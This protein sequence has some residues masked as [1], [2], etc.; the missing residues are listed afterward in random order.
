VG[1]SRV[2]LLAFHSNHGLTPALKGSERPRCSAPRGEPKFRV[3]NYRP[4]VMERFGL[5]FEYL[6]EACPRLVYPSAFR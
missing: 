3:Q 1:R 6:K 4:R 2:I 5:G